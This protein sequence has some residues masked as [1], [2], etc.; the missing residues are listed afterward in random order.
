M[1]DY[2]RPASC[3][4]CVFFAVLPPPPVSNRRGA[5]QDG[6]NCRRH[7]PAPG[8]DEFEIVFWPSVGRTDRCGQGAALTNGEGPTVTLCRDCIFW[9]QP[10][11]EP[12]K[13]AYRMGLT[14]EWWSE[15]GYCVHT[16]PFPSTEEG[17]RA[18]WKV[19][20]AGQGCGD[21]ERVPAC[22]LKAAFLSC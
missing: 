5:S 4:E 20:H 19:T 16:A 11:S 2:P 21:G 22:L 12:I 8:V 13:P 7:A 1:A 18:R 6:G 9:L 3:S 17:R 14:T 15:S 10:G